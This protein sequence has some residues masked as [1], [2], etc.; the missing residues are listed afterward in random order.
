[1]TTCVQMMEER[2]AELGMLIDTD[3]PRWGGEGILPEGRAECRC[4]IAE[5]ALLP[6]TTIGDVRLLVQVRHSP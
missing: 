3:T 4:Q 1:M 5:E 2:L 6:S